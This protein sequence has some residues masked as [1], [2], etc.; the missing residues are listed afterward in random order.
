[1]IQFF[2]KTVFAVVFVLAGS[3]AHAQVDAEP[4]PGD[5]RL[6]VFQYD[7]N[8]SYR[9]FTKPLAT[10]HIQF[11]NDERV[12]VLA[13]G[14]TVGWIT[15]QKDNNVFVKP[16]YP[17]S[18]T[19]GTLITTKRTYQFVFKSTTENG[20]WY[21]R[22]SFQNPSDMLIEA[23]DA[24]RRQLA[25]AVAERPSPSAVEE[26][27]NQ[28][29][30]PELMN[31]N[32]EVSGDARIKP[33]NVFDDGVATYIQIRQAEDVPAVFRLVDKEVELVEYV[34]KGNTIVIPRVLEAGLLKLGNQEVRFYNLKRGGKGLFGGYS[35]EGSGK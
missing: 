12:K 8:N 19:S 21:Q 9:V 18:S 24:D 22:V 33:L 34:L 26:R 29:V 3:W 16:R 2:L 17:N 11:D 32:Y 20:R 35:F 27:S 4:L 6:V 13:L 28:S 7:E 25:A 14:D 10:T 15:A 1:M 30:P 31:F 5:P 23:S